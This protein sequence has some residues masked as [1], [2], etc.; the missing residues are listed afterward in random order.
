M[1]KIIVLFLLMLTINTLA[2]EYV[3]ITLRAQ[4]EV[5]LTRQEQQS[6]L[7]A[8]DKFIN[9]DELL[10][11][12]DSYAAVKFIDGS[13][14][15]KLFP[16][17]ILKIQ[18]E[19]LEDKLNKSSFLEMG[20]IWTEVKKKTGIFEVETPTTVVSVKGT[21]FVIN[22]DETGDTMIIALSGELQIK[23]KHDEKISS[24]AAG[25]TAMAKANSELQVKAT[26]E[27]DI[28]QVVRD[29][30]REKEIEIKMEN[31]N[32]EEKTIKIKYEN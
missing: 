18:T 12:E 14:I 16:N 22:V 7:A 11:K 27:N 24:L 3:A 13:S 17:S 1:K 32:G 19:Q 21:E 25:N 26:E 10:T 6:N 31:K 5:I 15:V 2:Q 29:E 20:N 28:P 30:L 4:G 23:N 9:Y 8:G